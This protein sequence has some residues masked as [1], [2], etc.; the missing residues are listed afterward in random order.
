M[1]F[2]ISRRNR[3][4]LGSEGEKFWGRWQVRG[5]LWKEE[6]KA[7]I[8]GVAKGLVLR[9]A[10]GHSVDRALLKD[11]QKTHWIFLLG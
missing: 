6:G 9:K 3:K 11:Y 7:E 10:K 1:V 5:S 2:T 4:K 8:R